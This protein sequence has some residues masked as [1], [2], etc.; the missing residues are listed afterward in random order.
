[1]YSKKIY[2]SAS[3]FQEKYV[4]IKKIAIFTFIKKKDYL[5]FE[6]SGFC[7]QHNILMNT[8]LADY[9]VFFFSFYVHNLFSVFHIL[10][11][12]KYLFTSLVC[13]NLIPKL[14]EFNF[15]FFLLQIVYIKSITTILDCIFCVFSGKTSRH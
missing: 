4:I 14:R 1:M 11:C 5:T 8:K 2:S 7:L 6:F 3:L 15:F 9:T 13:S 10:D 12:L